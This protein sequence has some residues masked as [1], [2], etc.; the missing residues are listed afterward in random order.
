[1]SVMSKGLCFPIESI[2]SASPGAH[3]EPA[4]PVF[5]SPGDK[6][7]TQ[8]LNIVRIMQILGEPGPITIEFTKSPPR[9]KPEVARTILIDGSNRIMAEA[10]GIIGIM[11]VA[12]KLFCF[13]IEPI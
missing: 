11:L 12:K 5:I 1:M 7:V 4:C 6:I 9:T 8:R 3:P 2:Q 10:G 13:R